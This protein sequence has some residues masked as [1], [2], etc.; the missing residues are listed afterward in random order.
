MI[1]LLLLSAGLVV[2]AALAPCARCPQINTW[3]RTVPGIRARVSHRE[4]VTAL[5][6]IADG[7]VSPMEGCGLG[8]ELRNDLLE[9]NDIHV[10]R[11]IL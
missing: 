1:K 8:L 10:H 11:S 4:P 5:P 7:Y 2:V 3:H 6:T 9:R